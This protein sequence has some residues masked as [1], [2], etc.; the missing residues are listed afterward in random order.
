MEADAAL[1]AQPEGADLARLGS[2]GSTQQPGWPVRG[3]ARTPSSA[4]VSASAR[5]ERPDQ[6]TDEQAA[7]AQGQDRIGDQLARAVIG[8]LAAALDPDDLDPPPGEQVGLRPDE[9]LVGM[10]AE[11]QDGGVL[12]EQELV[13]DRPGDPRVDELALQRPGGA[14]VDPAEPVDVDLSRPIGGEP[15][16]AAAP[17]GSGASS[18][19][20]AVSMPPR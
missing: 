20:T 16:V 6:G 18:D 8:D 13:G 15:S 5:L 9:R 7:P 3:P 11:G 14:V 10:A 19:R 2:V 12:E 1:D 4:Q 17:I